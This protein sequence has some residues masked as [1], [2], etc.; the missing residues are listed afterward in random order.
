MGTTWNLMSDDNISIYMLNILF[1]IS[2]PNLPWKLSDPTMI[3]SPTGKGVII[4][5]GEKIFRDVAQRKKSKFLLELS[6]SMEWNIL[7]QTLKYNH[8]HPLAIPIPDDQVREKMKVKNQPR[9]IFRYSH[10]IFAGVGSLVLILIR[11][12]IPRMFFVS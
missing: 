10:L 2:G 3:T 7:G 11:T 9:K 8:I 4:M 6:N 5:G 1:Y 12:F